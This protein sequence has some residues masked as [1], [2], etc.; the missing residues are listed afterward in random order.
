MTHDYKKLLSESLLELLEEHTPDFFYIADYAGGRYIHVSDSIMDCLGHSPERFCAD[1]GAAFTLSLVHPNDLQPVLDTFTRYEHSEF[2]GKIPSVTMEYRLKHAKGHYIWV[3]SRDYIIEFTKE[4]KIKTTF[5]M[6]VCIDKVR[7]IEESIFAS[8]NIKEAAIDT[9][10]K[11]FEIKKDVEKLSYRELQIID[12]LSEGLSSKIIASRLN[13]S[14]DTVETHRKNILKKL[15]L[16]NSAQTV[17]LIS[18]Y[19]R[20]R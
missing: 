20:F 7:E 2:V 16:N 3:R 11:Y 1:N 8:F 6:V 12:F 18:K 17:N 4:G 5:G 14:I 9:Y 10:D 13:L 19:K 15:G